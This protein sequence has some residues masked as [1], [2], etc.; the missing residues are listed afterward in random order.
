MT[1]DR[2]TKL[3]A[4]E[5]NHL[6]QTYMNDTLSV[7]MLRHFLKHVED[8]DIQMAL[9]YALNISKTHIE[10][11]TK[12]YHEENHAIPEAFTD[13]DVNFEAPRLYSDSFYLNYLHNMGTLGLHA[14]SVAVAVSARSDV[15]DFF[16]QCLA[17]ANNLHKKVT[18]IL[19]EK[20]LYI[21]PPYIS[22]PT[23]VDFVGNQNFLTGWLGD[24]KSLLA[25]EICH[26]FFN[27][28]RNALAQALFISFSQVAKNKD[29]RL[30]MLR[31]KD[32]AAKH[33]DIFSS[34][35]RENDLNVPMSWD[36]E[37]TNCIDAPF[38]DRLMMYHIISISS[39]GIGFY[40]ASMGVSTR[41]DIGAH[42]TRLMAE[43][44]KYCD[45]S[46]NIMIKHKWMEQPPQSDDRE[47]LAFAK[48]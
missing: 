3:S 16:S 43:L 44:A 36:T 46:A 19:L 4:S 38:S 24:R 29:V 18:N 45:D 27:I 47:A 35:M 28:Q 22:I 33:I 12:L 14:Y 26:L 32:I 17:D 15:Y 10:F 30:H 6:W 11:I 20:G 8:R 41:R 21:R 5:V 42:Y 2:K 1:V 34:V 40:G 25:I 7:C 9:S 48:K 31:G 37:I 23:N 13:E 39:I